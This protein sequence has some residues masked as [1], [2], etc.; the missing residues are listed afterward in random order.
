MPIMP[1]RPFWPWDEHEDLFKMLKP[2]PQYGVPI[3]P[4]VDIY[5]TPKTVE[6]KM[7]LAG[8]RP[9][10]VDISVRDNVLTV[11]GKMEKKTEVEEKNYYRKEIRAGSFHRSIPLPKA[12]I[13][14][15]AKA[16][17]SEGMLMIS[18]PKAAEEKTK[19]IKVKVK[20]E[21]KKKK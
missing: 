5:E 1:M 4:P 17:F 12:V 19:A 8:V 11:K 14:G 6:I 7:P 15:K 16:Q 21:K 10:D 3:I 20:T 9:D 2:V 18:I 13:G